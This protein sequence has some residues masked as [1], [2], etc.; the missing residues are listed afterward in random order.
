M[1]A[2]QLGENEEEGAESKR[3]TDR[4]GL[5]LQHDQKEDQIKHRLAEEVGQSE[6]RMAGIEKASAREGQRQ[7]SCQTRR[8][9]GRPARLAR[10][11]VSLHQ[12]AFV[13]G[14]GAVDE[15]GQGL[16]GVRSRIAGLVIA[17]GFGGS[18]GSGTCEGSPGGSS[19]ARAPGR[20]PAESARPSA[21]RPR[22]RRDFT[23]PTGTCRISATSS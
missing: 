18:D 5:G 10:G 20:A 21:T 15:G 17:H 22:C 1:R 16:V 11:E 19:D 9:K 8:Q 4:T 13:V 12:L 3:L 2:M 6:E 23:V 14:R 7:Q